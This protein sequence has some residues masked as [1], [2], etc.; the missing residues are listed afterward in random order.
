MFLSSR[1]FLTASSVL[2]MALVAAT[3]A[4]AQERP[5]DAAGQL[6]AP[7]AKDSGEIVVTGTRTGSKVADQPVVA[8]T[9]DSIVNQGFTQIG[10]ALT[11]QPQFGVPANSTVGS[12]GSYGAGQSFSNLYNLGAQRTLTL[13]NGSRFVSAAASSV[14]G[15]SVGSP[16]DLGQIAP[17]LVERID[18]VSV[19][20]AP[21]Y[22][23][24]AI[25]GTVNIIL[26]KN[27][28]G[29]DVTASNGISEKGDGANSNVS[30]LAGKNFGDG[31]GNITLNV[32]Y[33][34][35]DGLTTA[36]R[37]VTSA[38]HPFFG[39]TTSDTGP[40][41]VVYF[42]GRRFSVVSNTGIPAALDN[43]PFNGLS[44]GGRT[45]QAI[46]NA[47]GQA[48]FFNNAGQLVPFQHGTV[49]GSVSTEAGGDG[50]QTANYGNLL[51]DTSRVQGVLMGHY[52]FSDHLRFHAEAW[53]SRNIATNKADQTLYNTALFGPAG[54]AAGNYIL[55]STNPYLSAA[56][57][58]TIQTSLA[59]A[60]QP[61]NQ[62]YLARANTDLFAGAF[63]TR[64]S[65]ARGVAG[66]DGD[67]EIGSHQFTWEGT[68]T[69][70]QVNSTS[71][72]VGLVWQNIQNALNAVVGPNGQ[73]TC[74][75]NY[76]NA[77]IATLS[78]TCA[79]LNIFGTGNVSQA[80]LNYIN[81]PA[82]S[83]QVNK[84][85]DAVFDIKGSLAHLP[86][87]DLQAVVGGEIRR[88]SQFF[89]PGAFFSG[90]YSQYAV[91]APV[92]G[93]YHTHEG[94]TE[95]T[96]PLLSPDMHI[97][98]LRELTLHGA[99]RYTDNSLNGGFWSYTGGGNWSPING[100]TLRG[101]F[102]RSFRAPSVTEAFAPI[103]TSFESG[104]DPCDAR[105][106]NGGASPATRAKNCAA[107]GVPGGFS[108]QI[109]E[110]TVQGLGG[111]NPQ[112][113][114][115]TANSWTVGGNYAVPFLRGLVLT[116]DYIHVDIKNEIVQPGIESI[117]QACYDSP[118]YPSSPFCSAFTRDPVS[119]EITNFSDTFLNIAS[120]NYRALQ[121]SVAYT[122]PLSR[123]GLSDSLGVLNLSSNYLHEFKNQQVIGT[124]S[125]Q[126]YNGAIGE[127]ANAVTSMIDWQTKRFDWSWTVIYD[128][129]TKV[130]PNNPASS[131]EYYNVSPYWMANTSI[132]VMVNDH[133]KL[134]GIVNNVFNMGVTYAGPV[135][136]FSPNKEFDAVFGRSYRITAEVKF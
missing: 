135:P 30:L 83:R 136:E 124:G 95:L 26:K 70:G 130:N 58:A 80:A 47:A 102:T 118:S 68:I 105:F 111:G 121:A 48:L 10:Q 53:A 12:Q 4:S 16:V 24:D 63:S 79:P 87:G 92:G 66:L 86:A 128:G 64:S 91:V 106:I 19:G 27:F 89:D 94:F 6:D 78:S 52:D 23:S 132:G 31:R 22:G 21:I 65:L 8:I 96:V 123:L 34:H 29:I 55:S 35:Q 1:K 122:L 129:P 114:N 97:P 74:A 76:T 113:N 134:R 38:S 42:G 2:A 18:V 88:E 54:D 61:T 37:Y 7:G 127:P 112:L 25:A 43:I 45:Y 60:G 32:F 99:A 131:Y 119:H 109:V 125:A 115:E 62:F 39:A 75:P 56:D 44:T 11:N 28:Q 15:A 17:A 110:S 20:G 67:F 100:L 116:A 85:F 104:N 9:G 103:A 82:I 49:T 84:Q 73:I 98:L 120:Q 13:V 107:A 40:A 126:I 81:A 93:S 108:S 133:F 51:T 41:N 50:F 3:A 101:N 90:A 46:T 69:Y 33:D 72:Q 59:A 57:Q 5:A 36:S 14:F 77:P 117:M 71:S